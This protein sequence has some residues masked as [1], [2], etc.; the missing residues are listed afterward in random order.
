MEIQFNG[1]RTATKNCISCER[2]SIECIRKD[3][4]EI[5]YLPNEHPFSL[6]EVR[7]EYS[8]LPTAH[9][10]SLDEVKREHSPLLTEQRIGRG[11]S[12]KVQYVPE[13]WLVDRDESVERSDFQTYKPLSEQQHLTH[14]E[15]RLERSGLVSCMSVREFISNV[16]E[17]V[18]SLE[19]YYDH[20][21]VEKGLVGLRETVSDPGSSEADWK[22][23]LNLGGGLVMQFRD[24][25]RIGN[26]P[27]CL[28]ENLIMTTGGQNSPIQVFG[29]DS[30]CDGMIEPGDINLIQ[31]RLWWKVVYDNVHNLTLT[32]SDLHQIYEKRI[33][34]FDGNNAGIVYIPRIPH[35]FS[36]TGQSLFGIGTIK[37]N[38]AI[39]PI[40]AEYY[41][42]ELES[43]R[44]YG[45]C[46][47]AHGHNVVLPMTKP[48]NFPFF[49]KR[50]ISGD[51]PDARLKTFWFMPENKR[52]IGGVVERFEQR[53]FTVQMLIDNVLRY[54]GMPLSNA[55]ALLVYIGG[56][57]YAQLDGNIELLELYLIENMVFVNDI[58]VT[59]HNWGHRLIPNSILPGQT[60]IFQHRIWWHHIQGLMTGPE[61]S[62]RVRI[63]QR[64][65]RENEEFLT[66][67]RASRAMNTRL[68][69]DA[70]QIARRAENA[71]RQQ[72]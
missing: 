13:G 2:K 10:L 18:L 20:A 69:E 36:K 63:L 53:F 25:F 52:C 54:A 27:P 72:R 60:L 40:S 1:F 12:Y 28:I 66:P 31:H 44:S 34:M 7:L 59:R 19:G 70:E 15:D 56:G 32:A 48:R 24:D 30:I 39:D 51:K 5:K 17:F 65:F 57:L 58:N 9:A 49:S 22:L 47:N 8:Q 16:F 55:H 42:E 33:E 3:S 67:I 43:M 41:E 68:I 21:L 64:F 6:V 23:F 71:Q 62:E 61:Y 14:L 50:E 11:A 37:L 26:V 29:Q 45:I 4:R 46:E 35:M 38:C